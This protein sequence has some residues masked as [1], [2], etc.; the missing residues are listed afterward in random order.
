VSIEFDDD[1]FVYFIFAPG[2][3]VKRNLNLSE[4]KK[5]RIIHLPPSFVDDL[6]GRGTISFIVMMM[7]IIPSGSFSS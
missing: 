6:D 5:A 3:Q 1:V 4:R 2:H 7:M